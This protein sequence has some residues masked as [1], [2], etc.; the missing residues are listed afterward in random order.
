MAGP[1]YRLHLRNYRAIKGREGAKERRYYNIQDPSDTI[2][3]REFQERA[4][5]IVVVPREPKKRLTVYEKRAKWMKNHI[6]RQHWLNGDDPKTAYISRQEAAE[7]PE[8][9]L[10]E[11]L[12][13][14]RDAD[15]REVGYDYFEQL[16]YEYE[17]EDWGETP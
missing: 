13:H 9:Q 10:F 16:E 14:S 6:N 17:H 15:V 8:F 2:S 5:R 11:R 12:I 3:V 1:K 4:K 7:L